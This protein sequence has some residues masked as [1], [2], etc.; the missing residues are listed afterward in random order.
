MEAAIL[1]MHNQ[2]KRQTYGLLGIIFN[3][4][5]SL[6]IKLHI[7]L[8]TDA[9]IVLITKIKQLKKSENQLNIQNGG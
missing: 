6:C 8:N 5:F 9:V 4:T 7:C 3:K 1:N 2:N